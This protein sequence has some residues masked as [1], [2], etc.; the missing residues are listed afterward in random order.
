MFEIE[1]KFRLSD[2]AIFLN[3]LASQTVLEVVWEKCVVETDTYFRHPARDFV[4]TDEALRVRRHVTFTGH[5][6]TENNV[7]IN[8][9][10]N[11]ENNCAENLA[12][13]NANNSILNC[14]KTA[15]AECLITYKGPRLDRETK[16]RKELELPLC[17]KTTLAPTHFAGFGVS[18]PT[19]EECA[20]PDLFERLD[21]QL[22]AQE[23]TS[24]FR[25]W[26]EMLT[27]LGFQ[28]VRNVCK[29][30]HKAW[31]QW[32]GARVEF[33][34]DIV[35]PVGT[36][37]ELEFLAENEESISTVKEK[38]LSLSDFLKLKEVEHRSYLALLM[39]HTNHT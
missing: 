21:T 2:P 17:T 16:I 9:E 27:L 33:S 20:A 18:A 13:N 4:V 24:I 8:A 5:Q 28:P 12:E 11:A 38:L 32:Q 25:K 30:R 14:P 10:N 7:E 22:D 31:T 19:A 39:S 29:I 26:A 6:P 15:E 37:V 3:M 23:E 35:P 1:Q 34:F 36:F